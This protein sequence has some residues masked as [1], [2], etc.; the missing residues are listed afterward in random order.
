MF[1][2]LPLS[3]LLIVSRFGGALVPRRQYS[4]LG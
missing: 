4:E 1:A 2:I 3:E